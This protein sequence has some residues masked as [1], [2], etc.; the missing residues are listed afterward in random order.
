M[1]KKNTLALNLGLTLTISSAISSS[2][3]QAVTI[4]NT[5]VAG[6]PATAAA[7]NSN[8]G[9]VKTAIDVLEAT[10]DGLAAVV[11]PVDGTVVG[12]TLVWDGSAWQ[13]TVASSFVYSK[14]CGANG[15]EEC[16]VGAVGP[17][18][19]F[20]F[21]VDTEDKYPDWNYLEVSEIIDLSQSPSHDMWCDYT[22]GII[23]LS[24]GENT[25]L[26]GGKAN[27]VEM[28]G[29]CNS[30]A[31]Y[32]A[33]S[34]SKTNNGATYSD[35]YLGTI[36]EFFELL[37]API[38]I[39]YSLDW[40]GYNIWISNYNTLDKAYIF[41]NDTMLGNLQRNGESFQLD[42]HEAGHYVLPIRQFK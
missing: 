28:K 5:F 33:T 41:R 25:K 35:W 10:V 18:G 14:V 19:G 24:L 40:S 38:Q 9:D 23:G 32:V 8:F 17:A 11:V 20:I 1:I 13:P 31:A 34:Y 3:V 39:L 29:N 6:Q 22:G 36:D 16:R 27:T 21:Y 7:V 12:Q 37:N 26:G 15:T 42:R 4:T 30:G 2:A